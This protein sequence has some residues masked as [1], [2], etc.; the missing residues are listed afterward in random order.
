MDFHTHFVLTS[1]TDKTDV[2][3]MVLCKIFDKVI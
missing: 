1:D 3:M 2:K